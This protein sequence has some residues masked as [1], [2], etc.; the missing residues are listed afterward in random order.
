MSDPCGE[1]LARANEAHALANIIG[2]KHDS[3]EATCAR[4]Y[5][6][7]RDS[8]DDLNRSI[9]GVYKILWTTSGTT[10][11]TLLGAVGTLAFFLLTKK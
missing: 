4:R 7:W 2:V 1:A 9:S 6:D 8:T 3:H 11:L 10:I 5:Q